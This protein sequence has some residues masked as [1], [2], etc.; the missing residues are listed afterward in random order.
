MA[1][2]IQVKRG[3]KVDMPQ[4]SAG[5]LGF[6]VDTNEVFIGNG[7]GNMNIPLGAKGDKGDKGEKGAD[8]IVDNRLC[9]LSNNAISNNVITSILTALVNNLNLTKV[10]LVKQDEGGAIWDFT[11]LGKVHENEMFIL[12]DSN[13]L[14]KSKVFTHDEYGYILSGGIDG[15]YAYL[16]IL[17]SKTFGGAE[18]E[19]GNIEILCAIDGVYSLGKVNGSGYTNYSFCDNPIGSRFMIYNPNGIEVSVILDMDGI[20]GY[21]IQL[22]ESIPSGYTAVCELTSIEFSP[23]FSTME[24]LQLYH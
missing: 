19:D 1:N 22:S 5:E 18:V 17:K 24:V 7:E 20:D 4:L 15:Y 21:Q 9:E 8:A 10:D 16:C 6:A 3:R 13:R 2:K 11:N 23:Y 12:Q 14:H